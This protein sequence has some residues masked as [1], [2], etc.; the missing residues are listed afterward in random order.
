MIAGTILAVFF[1]KVLSQRTGS[2]QEGYKVE[3]KAIA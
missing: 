3:T 1:V 2:P